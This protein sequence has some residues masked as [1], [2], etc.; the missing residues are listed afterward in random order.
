M[1]IMSTKHHSHIILYRIL[2]MLLQEELKHDYQNIYGRTS[3]N[4][5]SLKYV[6]GIIQNVFSS[7]A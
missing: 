4:T 1:A 2:K 3:D 6:A 7:Y 5:S